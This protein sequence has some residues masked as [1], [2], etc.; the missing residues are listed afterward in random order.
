MKDF[1]DQ[2]YKAWNDHVENLLPGLLKRNLLTKPPPPVTPASGYHVA[3]DVLK[4]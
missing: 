1:E 4:Q 2:T 3:E